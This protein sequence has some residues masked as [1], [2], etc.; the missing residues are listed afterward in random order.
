MEEVKWITHKGT[1]YKGS[2]GDFEAEW[3]TREDWDDHAK[4]VEEL[5]AKGEYMEEVEYTIELLH[6]PIWDE[7]IKTTNAIESYSFEMLD[8]KD[9]SISPGPGHRYV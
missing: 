3:W 7:P 2:V 4:Y 8:L 5:K 9:K 6:S 1:T